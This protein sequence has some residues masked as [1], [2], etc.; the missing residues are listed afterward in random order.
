MKTVVKQ[1]MSFALL[2]DLFVTMQR[3]M[4]NTEKNDVLNLYRMMVMHNMD[5]IA[6]DYIAYTKRV[7][8]VLKQCVELDEKGDLRYTTPL[9]DIKEKEPKPKEPLWK[10][11]EKFLAEKYLLMN[12]ET[13]VDLVKFPIEQILEMRFKVSDMDAYFLIKNLTT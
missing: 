8:A 9:I 4:Q 1:K 3:V 5:M 7:E 11:K 2:E 12:E 10:D 6:E 13:E